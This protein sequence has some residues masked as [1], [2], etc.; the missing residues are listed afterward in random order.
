M[1]V[2]AFTDGL[3]I[4]DIK[5]QGKTGTWKSQATILS[6]GRIPVPYKRL[7]PVK[8]LMSKYVTVTYLSKVCQ[9]TH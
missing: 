5:K 2:T 6:Q 1:S 8:S 4:S 9:H 7:T 3:G